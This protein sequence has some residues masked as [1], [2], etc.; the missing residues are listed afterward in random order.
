MQL[1]E[2]DLRLDLNKSFQSQKIKVLDF[3]GGSDINSQK[4]IEDSLLYSNVV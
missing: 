4:I 1:P 2:M 3:I